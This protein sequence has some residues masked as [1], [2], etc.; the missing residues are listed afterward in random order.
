M[1][2]GYYIGNK[3]FK[4]MTVQ[5]LGNEQQ[6]PIKDIGNGIIGIVYVYDNE[7]A[8]IKDNG[9]GYTKATSEQKKG[10][11]DGWPDPHNHLD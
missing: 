1:S 7:D 5:I 10:D 11:L 4:T 3:V 6:L 9:S 2:E 8:A